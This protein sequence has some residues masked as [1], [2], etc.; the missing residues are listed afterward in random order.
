MIVPVLSFTVTLLCFCFFDLFVDA[1][2]PF[3]SILLID[4]MTPIDVDR[5]I[6]LSLESYM[7]SVPTTAL[8]LMV[9]YF[10][11]IETDSIFLISNG[12]N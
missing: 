7:H 3:R 11:L 5:E 9:Y 12:E 2:S 10:L 1:C 8:F 6:G 4:F